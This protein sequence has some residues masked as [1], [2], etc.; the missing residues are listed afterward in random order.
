VEKLEK[1]QNYISNTRVVPDRYNLRD[2]EMQE[3]VRLTLQEP[4]SAI[5][6]SFHYGQAK[7]YRAAK[8]EVR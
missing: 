4:Y 8:R 5:S 3:L 7:G 6:L 1:I 2:S